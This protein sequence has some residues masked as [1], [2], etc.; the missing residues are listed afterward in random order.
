VS[1]RPLV[2]YHFPCSDGFT[3]AWCAWRKLGDTA[4]YLGVNYGDPVPA[5]DGRKVF[6]LDFSWKRPEMIDLIKRAGSVVV[7]DHHKS[8]EKELDRL[9]GYEGSLAT[10]KFDMGHSGARMAWDYFHGPVVPRPWLVDYVEDRDLWAWKLENSREV[11][12]AIASMPFDFPTWEQLAEASPTRR[13]ILLVEG[14]AI[15]R[16]QAQV[17]WAHAEK[18]VEVELLGHKVPCVNATTLVSEIGNA[19]CPGRPFSVS[20]FVNERGRY[21]LSLRSDEAGLDVSEVAVKLGGGGHKHA[22]GA[23]LDALPF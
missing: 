13:T 22:A 12:A 9:T 5:V 20:Y 4:D 19:L 7:L 14:A 21:V 1:D 8:A 17:V 16:Y 3:A 23:T 15:L 18:A 11:S 6:I 2:L 10:V